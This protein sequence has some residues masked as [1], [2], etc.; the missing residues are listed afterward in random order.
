MKFRA[1]KLCLSA[2]ESPEILSCKLDFTE[3]IKILYLTQTFKRCDLII[4]ANVTPEK[5]S[6]VKF[7]AKQSLKVFYGQ[8]RRH[9][10]F[11]RMHILTLKTKRAIFS[12]ADS[13][14]L[15]TL[16]VCFTI[17]CRRICIILNM[18]LL[19]KLKIMVVLRLRLLQ[20]VYDGAKVS[21][22]N[23]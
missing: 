22:R 16:C 7:L 19:Y 4:E 20:N 5:L 8:L 21:S 2:R 13:V 12:K 14:V 10:H 6:V 23:F 15:C 1:V 3:E 17:V 18:I 9:P 11:K